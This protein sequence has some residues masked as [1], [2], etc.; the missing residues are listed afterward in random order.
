ME[1]EELVLNYFF[2]N[3]DK[4]VYALKNM[5]PAIQNYAYMGVSRFANLR[6]RFVKILQ[7]KGAFEAVVEA[8][9]QEKSVEEALKPVSEFSAEKNKAVFFDFGHKSAGEGATI[10]IVSEQNPIYATGMQ[11]DFYYP[12]TTMEFS[13]RYAKGF[14]LDKVYWDKELLKSE[15]AK[16]AKAVVSKNLELYE[17][18]FDVLME[19]LKEKREKE[20]LPE[21]VS[22]LDSLRFLIPI[23]CH[24]SVI[25]GG[26]TRAVL[27]HFRKLLGY[28]DCFVQEYAKAGIEEATKVFPEYFQG[29]KADE[30]VLKREET[31][32]EKTKGIFGKK[33]SAVKENVKMF[34]DLEAEETALAQIL[35]PH[36]NQ[37]FEEVFEKVSSFTPGERKE[38]FDAA[39]AGRENRTNPVRGFETRPLIFEVEAPWAL[40]KDFKRGRMNLRFQ[41][42]MRGLAGYDTPELIEGS[43]LEKDYKDAM[44][45]TS[46]LI[47]KIW[48]KHG[49]LSKTVAAQGSRKRFLM[50]MGV[51]QLTVLGELRTCGEGDKGYRKIASRMIELAKQRKPELFSHVKD[52]FKG[53]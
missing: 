50:C 19:R 8:I 10:F 12:L 9:K 22:V 17:K 16:E 52:N 29:L 28:K 25:L 51:R 41:Q 14:S 44:E 3:A 26:N 20:E 5:P 36:C 15:F 42:E 21:K 35:Y 11:Q 7:D 6:E 49:Q 33:F 46:K 39:N 32:R 2:T 34:I 13:T 24:T 37:T 47:E 1:N 38:I 31:L 27:E 23:S 40:W 53:N 48:E 43:A 18:G 45:A 30:A 4:P